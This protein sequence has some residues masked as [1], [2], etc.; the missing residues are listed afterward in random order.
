[1]AI[2]Q[3]IAPNPVYPNSPI[4]YTLTISNAG[5]DNS[6][7]ITVTDNLPPVNFNFGGASGAGWACSSLSG[8][9]TCTLPDLAAG[10]LTTIN[11]T[12]T[13]AASTGTLTNTASVASPID[14]VPG[15]NGPITLVTTIIPLDQTITFASLPDKTYGDPDFVITATAS[16]GLPV[17]FDTD[18]TD[19][20]TNTGS[21]I[22]LTGAGACTI[23]A[24]QVGDGIYNPAAP[25]AHAFTINPA[26]TTVSVDSTPNPAVALQP[27]TL[28]ATVTSTIGTPT[29]SVQ[30]YADGALFGGPLTLSSGSATLVTN[31]LTVG[32]HTITGTYSGATNYAAANGT[33]AGGQV[34]TKADQT[35][36]FAS[37]PDKT[38]GDPDFVI[39]ATASSGLPVSFSV[40]VTDQC[41]NT[42]STIHLTG[43]GACTITATQVGDGTYNPAT[44]V[45]HTFTINKAAATVTLASAPNPVVVRQ[46][47]T[48]T[49]TVTST[50]GT[51]NGTVQLYADGSLFGASIT[52]SSGSATL[53]TNTLTVGTHVITATYSGATNYLPASATL[54]G[55]Q[56]VDPVLL[57]LPLI[58]R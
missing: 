3:A 41:T 45:A 16:S 58:S 21:T 6:S 32:T 46:P 10:G 30:L 11:I 19:Q 35:I 14:P 51:P 43:A 44:P 37:L 49:A 8:V 9:V 29:G 4:T 18:A 55:G 54:L 5:P 17:S 27:V 28:T 31:T 12:G 36:T 42:G 34:I 26:A 38:Y 15:N 7:L 39:T 48:L 57:Y 33:L 25:V 56:V 53:V 13:V 40:G 23:T 50:I 47:I 2:S 20:C 52:L 24:T 1:V 22:H